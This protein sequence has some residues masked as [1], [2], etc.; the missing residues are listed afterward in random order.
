MEIEAPEQKAAEFYGILFIFYSIYDGTEDK[1][2]VMQLCCDTI[3][4]FADR[5]LRQKK[6][7]LKP[8][9]DRL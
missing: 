4:D 5:E 6:T 7:Y 9:G 8:A 3:D 2:R 1:E